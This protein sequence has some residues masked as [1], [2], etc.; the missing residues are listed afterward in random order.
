MCLVKYP[1]ESDADITV[2]VAGLAMVNIQHDYGLEQENRQ[3]T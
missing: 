3:P 1:R 2:M